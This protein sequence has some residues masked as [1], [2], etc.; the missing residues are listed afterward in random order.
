MKKVIVIMVMA[1]TVMGALA[2]SEKRVQ[3]WGNVKLT[4]SSPGMIG[5]G[6]WGKDPSFSGQ[7]GVN[8]GNFVFS[9]FRTSD[10]L[11]KTS[12][13]NQVDISATYSRKFG[14]WKLTLGNDVLLFD[15]KS[16]DMMIPR[17]LATYSVGKFAVEG[18][19]TYCPLFSGG[20]MKIARISPAVTV[21]GYSFRLF[22]WA[23][24]ANGSYSTPA[25]LQVGKKL[26]QFENGNSL[27]MTA[28]YHVK[29]IAVKKWEPFG[30]VGIQV[31]F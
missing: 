22:V 14:H 5:G 8:V 4:S 20:N 6:L 10:L 12:N 24:D 26:F 13:A 29:D 28:A 7:V 3:M 21:E 9:A 18:M 2:Q 16:M 1:M 27:S 23:K 11:D 17:V 25:S 30:W 15:N 19:V 31:D